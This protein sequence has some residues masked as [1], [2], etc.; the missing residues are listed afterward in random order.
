ML[1]HKG[2]R[3]I[4]QIVSTTNSQ[5]LFMYFTKRGSPRGCFSLDRVV[6]FSH[7]KNMF[8]IFLL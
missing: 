1:L 2:N 4:R 7:S 5:K 3:G 8:L 6:K